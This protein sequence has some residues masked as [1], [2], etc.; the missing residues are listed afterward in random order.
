M[1]EALTGAM[2]GTRGRRRGNRVGEPAPQMRF[3][4][5]DIVVLLGELDALEAV[6]IRALEATK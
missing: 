6:G 1:V 4:A 3:E 5:G 2:S